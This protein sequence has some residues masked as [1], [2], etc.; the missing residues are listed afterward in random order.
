MPGCTREHNVFRGCRAPT[1]RPK[2]MIS[3]YHRL[4]FHCACLRN[5]DTQ[6]FQNL[7]TIRFGNRNFSMPGC[8]GHALCLGVPPGP[9]PG[10]KTMIHNHQ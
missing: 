2:S 8:T 9:D 3:N 5:I 7:V 1:R 6:R 4:A 10:S